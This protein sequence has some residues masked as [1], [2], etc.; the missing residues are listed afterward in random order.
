MFSHSC[1]VCLA[2]GWLLWAVFTV[3][4]LR[5]RLIGI[6]NKVQQQ[7]PQRVRG[8]GLRFTCGTAIVF[9]VVRHVPASRKHGILWGYDDE[10]KAYIRQQRRP[11]TPIQPKPT[12]SMPHTST[13][14]ARY[15][16]RPSPAPT[17]N[18]KT[19]TPDENPS[20]RHGLVPS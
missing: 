7:S 4:L 19:N 3:S 10:N 6:L 1:A 9:F 8:T 20:V 12:C 17:H 16:P 18:T 13:L 2:G 15:T 5:Y 11:T 14:F